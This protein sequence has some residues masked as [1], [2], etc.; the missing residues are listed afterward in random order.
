MSESSPSLPSFRRANLI[1]AMNNLHEQGKSCRNCTGACCT[2]VFNSMQI[3]PLEAWDL[4]Q[5]LKSRNEWTKDLEV[6]LLETISSFRLDVEPP[7]N[8]LRSYTRRRYTCP[9]FLDKSLGCPL[10]PEAKPYGCLAFNPLGSAVKDGEN[11]TSSQEDLLQRE[12]IDLQEKKSNDKIIELLNL[13]WDK[14]DLP[15]ALIDLSSTH[16]FTDKTP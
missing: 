10:P 13:T 8:G 3:T 4:Y 12:S 14:R 5:H 6:R 7:G 1:Q 11:C 2:F 16:P 9:F 15:R